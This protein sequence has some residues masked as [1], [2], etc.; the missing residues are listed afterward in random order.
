MLS[1]AKTVGTESNFKIIHK[2]RIY[3]LQK[4]LSVALYEVVS[5]DF[6]FGVTEGTGKGKSRHRTGHEGTE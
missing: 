1:I 3:R 4:E 6:F 5:M 2:R